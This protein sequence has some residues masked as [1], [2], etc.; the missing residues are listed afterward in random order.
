[1]HCFLHL[2]IDMGDVTGYFL[3]FVTALISIAG[4]YYNL[5]HLD[6]NRKTNRGL[7]YFSV[8]LIIEVFLISVKE[9][10]V[11]TTFTNRI[12]SLSIIADPVL[13]LI[14]A[15]ITFKKKD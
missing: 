15:L 8:L 10:D 7:I 5:K 14:G 9:N 4:I 6:V 12:D 2:G 3:S 11:H 1:M 13:I